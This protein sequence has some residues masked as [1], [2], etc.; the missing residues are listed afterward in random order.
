MPKT[1]FPHF[2]GGNPRWWKGV[3]EKYF[4]MYHVPRDTWPAFATVHLICN[5]ALWLQT[6][7]E[8]HEVGSWE[9]LVVAIHTK[10]G[11]DKH[12]QYLEAL[13]RCKQI[14]SVE[15]ITTISKS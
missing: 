8:D 11:K 10:F 5:A 1:N 4:S 12:L 6:Y 3:C 14:D 15:I 13:E 9:E 7:E 2:D